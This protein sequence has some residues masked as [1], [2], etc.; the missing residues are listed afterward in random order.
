MQSFEI[1]ESLDVYAP[2]RA[3]KKLAAEIGFRNDC[4]TELAIVVSELVS[5]VVKYG[6]S[7]SI[8]FER[9]LHA[10]HGSGMLIVATDIGPPFHDLDLA[11]RDG[12]N[13]RGPIDPGTLLRRGGLGTGLGAVV[14]LTDSFRVEYATAQKSIVVE[15]FLK[16]P[17]RPAIAP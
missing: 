12:Y 3:V 4:C 13:D 15:R 5:N 7:G 8:G 14:R 10:D 11:L 1:R 9:L 6:V 17:R 16:R 2:R